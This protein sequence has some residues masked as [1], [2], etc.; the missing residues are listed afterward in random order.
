MW[1]KTYDAKTSHFHMNSF[2]RRTNGNA[3]YS[4]GVDRF[5]AVDSLDPYS[6]LEIAQILS[7]KVPGIAVCLLSVDDLWFDNETAHQHTLKDKNVF[8]VG[9]SILFS[10]QMPTVRKFP[11][12]SIIKVEQPSEDFKEGNNATAFQALQLYARF[13]IQAYHA[14]KIAN[15]YFNSLPMEEYARELLAGQVPPEFEVPVD[16]TNGSLK[17]GVH[18][19]I[20]KILYTSNDST[21]ALERISVMWKE[22][23]TPLTVYW[24]AQFYNL[25]DL[26]LP[27]EFGNGQFNLERYSA[28][29]L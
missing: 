4:P 17:T 12:N 24:R 18:R 5:F 8:A 29:I 7:S 22:N 15:M 20:T 16:N 11:P 9:A 19:E 2:R 13:V 1:E 6:S 25:L 27:A 28:Y 26:T 3:Y 10:R 23:N 21:E 14:S